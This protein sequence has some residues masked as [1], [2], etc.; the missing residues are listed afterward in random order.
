MN[1]FK[2]VPVVSGSLSPL[3]LL[4]LTGEA[5]SSKANELD[6]VGINAIL[7]NLTD[8]SCGKINVNPEYRSFVSYFSRVLS[9]LTSQK[10]DEKQALVSIS[11][12]AYPQKIVAQL[13]PENNEN[14]WNVW[15]SDWNSLKKEE[16]TSTLRNLSDIVYR[17]ISKENKLEFYKCYEGDWY[18]FIAQF[19]KNKKVQAIIDLNNL[20]NFKSVKSL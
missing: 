2:A 1:I 20:D 5:L 3:C 9:S 8:Y 13:L 12:T 18:S 17:S 4:F 7:S 14:H 10:D 15:V 6:S 11:F 16:M 19:S